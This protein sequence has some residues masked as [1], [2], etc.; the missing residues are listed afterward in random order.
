[1]T[2]VI[3]IR[4]RRRFRQR[5]LRVL[6]ITIITLV[7]LEAFLG[8]LDPLG[9]R[10]V[11]QLGFMQPYYI[12]GPGGY[13]LSA[14]LYQM[15]DW[16]ATVSDDLTRLVP[17]NTGG[18][19]RLA[20]VGDSVTWGWAVNDDQTFVNQIS[21]ALPSIDVINAGTIAYNSENVRLLVDSLDF[22]L[23]VYLIVYNDNE[24]AVV[25]GGNHP[26]PG[27]RRYPGFG[28][29]AGGES[30]LAS[31]NNYLLYRLLADQPPSSDE[32]YYDDIA[33]LTQRGD[34]LL[35]AY[36]EALGK[37]TAERFP[38]TVLPQYTT[39]ISAADAHPDAQG[40]RQ[41]AEHMLPTIQSTLSNVCDQSN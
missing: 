40:H 36:D 19:C 29:L 6:L 11:Y 20:F 31:Y 1:M 38:V 16:Q 17:D 24:L 12:D 2:D 25:K 22:D 32:R 21:Q 13:R 14:G 37:R 30:A 35:F 18:S 41:A 3:I 9:V 23:A 33:H 10:Y 7:M 4:P 34:V 27:V 26:A 15:G 8:F 28:I 39:S 5:F